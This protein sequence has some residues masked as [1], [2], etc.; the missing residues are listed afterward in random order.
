M[1]ALG[2]FEFIFLVTESQLL[3]SLVFPSPLTME[4][5]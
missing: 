4:V 1:Y 5:G 2:E 3:K